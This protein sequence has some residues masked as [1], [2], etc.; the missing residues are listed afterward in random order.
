MSS[1]WQVSRFEYPSVMQSADVRGEGRDGQV[2]AIETDPRQKEEHA[3]REA[4]AREIGRVEGEAKAKAQYEEMARKERERIAEAVS[5]FEVERTR[6]FEQVEGE[7]VQLA[8]S[9]ARKVLHR[10]A[11]I[12]PELLMGLVRY[13]LEKLRDGTRVKLRVH[14][15]GVN[16]WQQ[17]LGSS[18]LEVSADP[19]LER[20]M[21]VVETELGTTAVSVDAQLKEIEQGLMDL[22]AHRPE[23]K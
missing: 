18:D 19:K 14:P 1:D 20:G 3:L 21:C 12:D 2:W 8:L 7:V 13:T 10:E 17:E 6:Y 22:L 16:A 23:A 9:I 4:Q 11:Q 15:A 5:E